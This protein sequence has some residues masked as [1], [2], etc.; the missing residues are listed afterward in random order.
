MLW[1]RICVGAAAG[2]IAFAGCRLRRSS[3]VSRKTTG[4]LAN[5]IF[6]AACYMDALAM[7][8]QH[9]RRIGR[10]GSLGFYRQLQTEERPGTRLRRSGVGNLA[11]SILAAGQS[12]QSGAVTLPLSG[13]EGLCTKSLAHSMD[14]RRWVSALVSCRASGLFAEGAG[15]R[16]GDSQRSQRTTKC[17]SA[18]R[19]AASIH[20]MGQVNSACRFSFTGHSGETN[21]HAKSMFSR[22]RAASR[23]CR[24]AVALYGYVLVLN[25]NQLKALG[26][27]GITGRE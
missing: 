12:F 27:S 13:N 4:E 20:P 17:A 1:L 6:V 11:K 15:Q 8:V 25:S 26:I 5:I 21:A 22:Q 18:K 24:G 16:P 23:C 9:R 2:K 19:F 7:C 3:T 10:S 14:A